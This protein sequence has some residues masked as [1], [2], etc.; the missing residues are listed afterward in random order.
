MH[1]RFVDLNKKIAAAAVPIRMAK[2]A[3]IVSPRTVGLLVL[4]KIRDVL[5]QTSH[6]LLY[7]EI[8]EGTSRI[9]PLMRLFAPGYRSG[10]P[11]LTITL[12]HKD[13]PQA[14]PLRGALGANEPVGFFLPGKT[15]HLPPEQMASIAP[16]EDTLSPPETGKLM[17][18]LNRAL[19]ALV[20]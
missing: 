17:Y 15:P 4:S 1:V 7:G 5:I 13:Y 3:E 18:A 8:D 11:A 14:A 20:V 6:G 9:P 19:A 2:K 16:G 12:A 10:L